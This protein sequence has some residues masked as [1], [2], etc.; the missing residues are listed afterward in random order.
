MTCSFGE[1]L[2]GLRRKAGKTLG[3]LAAV[4]AVSTVYLSDVER[5]NRN[6]FTT[7]RIIKI[8]D[9]LDEDPTE[10]LEA[11]DCE[12]GVIEYDITNG[13]PLGAKVVGGLVTGLA[14]GGISDEQL[15]NIQSILEDPD[16]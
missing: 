7:E 14:R 4:L 6:P 1:L 5:G 9:Y 15:R 11:A 2:R 13:T 10:L 8:A 3:D 12:R 16:K